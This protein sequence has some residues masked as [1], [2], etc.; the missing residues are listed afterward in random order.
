MG[1]FGKSKYEQYQE[2]KQLEREEILSLYESG[3]YEQCFNSLDMWNSRHGVFIGGESWDSKNYLN[4]FRLD[5][6]LI[7]LKISCMAKIGS[8]VN[9]ILEFVHLCDYESLQKHVSTNS[10][11]NPNILDPS[12]VGKLTMDDYQQDKDFISRLENTV[13]NGADLRGTDYHNADFR[14]HDFK[15]YDFKGA[16]LRGANLEKSH[17]TDADLRGA[18]LSGTNLRNTVLKGADLSGTNLTDTD[19]SGADLRGADLSGT[20]LRGVTLFGDTVL[21]GADLRGANLSGVLFSEVDLRNAD[22]TD[23]DLTD[24]DLRDTDLSG[25]DLTDAKLSPANLSDANLSGA[26]LS[27]ANLSGA[28]LSG[29][30][31]SGANLS[32]TNLSGAYLSGVNLSGTDLSNAKLDGADLSGA[33]VSGANVS[34]AN[35]S[36]ANASGTEM[37]TKWIESQNDQ[38]KVTNNKKGGALPK[39]FE[40]NSKEDNSECPICKSTIKATPIGSKTVGIQC[41]CNDNVERYVINSG[42][43]EDTVSEYIRKSQEN[44]NNS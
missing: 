17:L 35:V 38:A 39:G 22:L 16:D 31:L 44:L 7:E 29:T 5:T 26:N 21:N 11:S 43:V 13:W 34:G 10:L 33:N 6:E 36:G 40:T 12:D 15:C 41:N 8:S 23:A 20:D 42:T 27:G 28:Y 4:K 9:D 2:Q 30:D 19:L 25:A 37:P 32:G 14:Q 3:D 18:K 1:L 24:A